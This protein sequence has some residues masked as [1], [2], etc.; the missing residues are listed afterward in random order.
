[1]GAWEKETFMKKIDFLKLSFVVVSIIFFTMLGEVVPGS[2]EA[3]SQAKIKT[4]VLGKVSKEQSAR[5]FQY[6]FPQLTQ[7]FREVFSQDPRFEV[8]STEELD[9]ALV[10][11][12][13][14]KERINPDDVAQLRKI[15]KEAGAEL[16]FVS[17]Y[18]EM[19]GHGMPMHSNNVLTLAWVNKEEMVKIDRDYSRI[20]SE[21]ELT[22]S[23][24]MAFKELMK[25][26]ESM[27]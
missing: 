19:G 22:S 9:K 20:L 4:A 14:Q 1:M 6:L 15:G 27:F 18:Y 23:D 10:K 26:A 24:E 11:A 8:I 2:G 25:K 5:R 21:T 7:R 17:Y 16:I 3:H 12:E 13:V